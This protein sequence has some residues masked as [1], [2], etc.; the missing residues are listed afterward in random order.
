[1]FKIKLNARVFDCG[2]GTDGIIVKI[3]GNLATLDN[4]TETAMENLI[5]VID[6][7]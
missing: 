6:T 5:P 3:E 1:M 7:H 4:G 2:T